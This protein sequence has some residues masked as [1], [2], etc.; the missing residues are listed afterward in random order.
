M[1]AMNVNDWRV[2]MA[3]DWLCTPPKDREPN[4]MLRLCEM[5]EISDDVFRKWRKDKDFLA[6][7]EAKAHEIIGS[8]ERAQ[9]VLDALYETACDRTDPRQVPAA[10]A[11]LDAIK[12]IRPPKPAAKRV[13]GKALREMSDEELAQVAAAA[14]TEELDRR[15]GGG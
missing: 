12:E 7:W 4:T 3:I 6:A 10:R 13:D 8:P 1:G 2:Q 5:L 9:G 14:V 11:Y 15:S